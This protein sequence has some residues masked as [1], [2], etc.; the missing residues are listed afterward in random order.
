M[1]ENKGKMEERGIVRCF[2]VPLTGI[3]TMN[4]V[5]TDMLLC[6][7]AGSGFTVHVTI[8]E[9]NLA[10]LLRAVNHSDSNDNEGFFEE[11]KITQEYCAYPIPEKYQL[12]VVLH[13][14]MKT[15]SKYLFM[16]L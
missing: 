1:G 2:L 14:V 6:G 5:V 10:P 15:A 16:G 4:L 9:A 12:S 13:Q 7:F 8:N 11:I 3:L